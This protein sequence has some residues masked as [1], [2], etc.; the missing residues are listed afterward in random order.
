MLDWVE[1][2]ELKQKGKQ[3]QNKK[4]Q[5]TKQKKK[6]TKT[7]TKTKKKR[8]GCCLCVLV[9]FSSITNILQEP[10]LSVNDYVFYSV[11]IIRYGIVIPWWLMHLYIT[12]LPWYNKDIAPW[13]AVFSIL[14]MAVG[15]SFIQRQLE[16]NAG[17]FFH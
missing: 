17:Q 10:L 6:K 9:Y 15:S 11:Y 2:D 13:I 1:I 3:K 8:K 5:K 16:E 4:N 14:L 12:Y 7:K